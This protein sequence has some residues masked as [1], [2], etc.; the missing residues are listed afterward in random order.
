M[1]KGDGGRKEW[2]QAAEGN[3][4]LAADE[5]LSSFS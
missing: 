4:R 2:P 3:N 5:S 1:T